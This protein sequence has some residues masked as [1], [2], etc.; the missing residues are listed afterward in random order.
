MP[1]KIKKALS[2]F[3]KREWYIFLVLLGVLIVSTFGILQN[4]NKSF[5]VKVP[6]K[7][8]SVTEGVIGAPRFINPV[9][10]SS[11][12]DKDL[13]SLIYSGLMRKDEKGEL[14]PDLAESYTVSEDGL[15]YTFTLKE[16]VYFHDGTPLTADDVVFTINQVKDGV[17]K[18][19]LKINWDA[20]TVEKIDDKNITFTLRQPH[21]SF[22]GNTTLGIMPASLWADSPIEL[23]E[24]NMHPIGS[25]PYKVES[26]RKQSSGIIDTYKL[27]AYKKFSLGRPYITD[28][29]FKFY[30]N[31][32]ELL[33]A[34]SKGEVK[35]INSITPLNAE[36]LST[37][38]YE[39]K[40]S[41][42]PRIFGLFFN[43][44][45]NQI[46]TNKN[47]VR[48]IDLAI[49]KDRIVREVLFGYGVVIDNPI[50]P[51]MI[52]YQKLSSNDSITFEENKI[53]AEEILTKDGWTKN[54]EGFLT[55]VT[56]DAKKVKT[57]RVLEF[58][59]STGNAPELAKTA[60][61]IK[62]NLANIGIKVE[63]QTFEIGDLNQSVIRPRKYD[64]LLFGQIINHESDLFAFWH[65]SQIK[66]PGLNVAM[67]TNAKV[68]KILEDAST[69][70]N[71]NE[72][73]KKYAQ[74]ED[75]IKK[76]FPAVF[77]YS[78]SFIYV[79]YKNIQ[80]LSIDHMI[81]ARDRLSN[82]Y[83]WY[84]KTDSVWKIFTKKDN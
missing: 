82:S 15:V 41:I 7:G 33:S 35:Q 39:I 36:K 78:P 61:M 56:T 79:V 40:S 24:T 75:E 11:D 6:M 12:A 74:F 25:G 72:R 52:N 4:I 31:E 84:I 77:L 54:D 29:T 50:P 13:V 80:N 43:Q 55:K 65:S 32:E 64:A 17:V 27:T 19:P 81:S 48:A 22:L 83:L 53:K 21:A 68:D 60:E 5:M 59:I 73:I 34:L 67:Y 8:G 49:D 57:T 1:F 9:L 51:N 23:N 45:Q 42:L 63:I 28:I 30:Q 10:A 37:Q 70:I 44:S 26:F 66:D 16:D 20:V 47:V 14:I 62:N 58:S 46:F 71:E 3:S 69:T 76:D 2:H 18:S 38:N